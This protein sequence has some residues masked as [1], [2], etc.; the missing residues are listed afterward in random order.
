M[1]KYM[2]VHANGEVDTI[3]G[4]HMEVN[5]KTGQIVV[6]QDGCLRTIIAA[7]PPTTFAKRI[8]PQPSESKV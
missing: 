4:N 7:A 1:N 8:E 3:E 6:Y 2:L 5:E